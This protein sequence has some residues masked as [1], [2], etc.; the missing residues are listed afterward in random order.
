MTSYER[1]YRVD[2][3][4]PVNVWFE[5]QAGREYSIQVCM[6]TS[7]VNAALIVDALN[8]RSGTFRLCVDY[9]KL[10][11]ELENLRAVVKAIEEADLAGPYAH[12]VRQNQLGELALIANDRLRAELDALKAN[13]VVLPSNWRDQI[14]SDMIPGGEESL[15]ER[16][17]GRINAWRH[18]GEYV[19]Q[20]DT[21]ACR[22][23]ASTPDR[24]VARCVAHGV[25]TCATCTLNPAECASQADGGCSTYRDTGMHWDTCPNRVSAITDNGQ[26]KLTTGDIID[27]P[28][29][30]TAEPVDTEGISDETLTDL[31]SMA[32]VTTT[33]EV[34]ATWTPRQRD[35]AAGWAAAVCLSASDNDVPVPPRPTFLDPA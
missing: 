15:Y 34:V 7:P 2:N 29:Q 22:D 25:P 31:L 18:G 21:L 19:S 32:C 4:S 3:H 9:E 14:A 26:W 35:Q 16:I 30:S 6:A 24:P 8:Q 28:G 27:P 11:A 20:H 13:A 10:R 12:L 33:P 23:P 5:P 17:T 1:P